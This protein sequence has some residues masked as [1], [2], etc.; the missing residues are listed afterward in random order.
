MAF[1]RTDG[2]R[3]SII[4]GPE[5]NIAIPELVAAKLIIGMLAVVVIVGIYRLGLAALGLDQGRTQVVF[6]NGSIVIDGHAFDRRVSHGFDLE[7]HHLASERIIE[8][9]SSRYPRR[10]TTGTA[11]S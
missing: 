10:S 1:S 2:L 9:G 7:P 11:M 5:T 6:G 4:V 3:P 8:I